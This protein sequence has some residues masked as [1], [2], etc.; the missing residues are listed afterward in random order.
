MPPWWG[1]LRFRYDSPDYPAGAI[2]ATGWPAVNHLSKAT[3]TPRI[4]AGA[5]NR[6]SP[7]SSVSVRDNFRFDVRLRQAQI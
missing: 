7:K 2:I 4:C 1:S 5:R 6:P 3:Q